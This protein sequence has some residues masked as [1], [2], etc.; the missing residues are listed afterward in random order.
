MALK[1]VFDADFRYRNADTTD[2][3]L[4]FARIRREQQK[5]RRRNEHDVA[6]ALPIDAPASTAVLSDSRSIGTH[7]LLSCQVR[8]AAEGQTKDG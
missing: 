8:D 4:T 7:P 5:A 2:V 6:K 1:T 3:R